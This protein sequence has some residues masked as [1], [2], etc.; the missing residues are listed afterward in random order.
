MRTAGALEVPV[1]TD[2]VPHQG[3]SLFYEAPTACWRCGWPEVF[4]DPAE[5]AGGGFGP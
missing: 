1:S 3:Q 5:G 4:H 2:G